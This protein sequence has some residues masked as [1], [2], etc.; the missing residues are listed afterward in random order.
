MEWYKSKKFYTRKFP[1]DKKR[2][3]D[4]LFNR[5]LKEFKNPGLKTRTIFYIRFLFESSDMNRGYLKRAS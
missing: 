2:A 5:P 4:F 1:G 3:V